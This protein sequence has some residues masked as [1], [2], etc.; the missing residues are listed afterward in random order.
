LKL[1]FDGTIT[2]TTDVCVGGICLSNAFTGS[3]LDPFWSSNYTSYNSSWSSIFNQTYEDAYQ[4]TTN[5]TFRLLDNHTFNGDVNIS[6]NLN[7]SDSNITDVNILSFIYEEFIDNLVD[8]WLRIT[9]NLNV[10]GNVEF[11]GDANITGDLNTDGNFTGNQIYGGM[12]G[13]NHTAT[14]FT[15]VDGVYAPIPMINATH[16][17]GFTHE[18]DGILIG[19]NLTTQVAGVYQITYMASGSG[20][21]NH[22]Y[23]T[24][25]FC[26]EVNQDNCENH[27]KMAAGGDI[28]TQSGNCL[29]ELAVGDKVSMRTADIGGSGSGNYY[30]ANLNLVRIGD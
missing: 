18:E 16:L 5:D 19:S 12:W 1:W 9:G 4:Y 22:T 8:G 3:E 11:S 29:I 25:I 13:H 6:G 10:T 20:Q 21:N 23:Y 2:A 26:N 28:V 27:K 17:N 15:F 30:S 7:M 24:S 14:E